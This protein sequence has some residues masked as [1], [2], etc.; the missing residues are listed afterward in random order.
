MAGF[1][2]LRLDESRNFQPLPGGIRST[3]EAAVITCQDYA[4]RSGI[5]SI[6]RNS[7]G[8]TVY[9]SKVPRPNRKENP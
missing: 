5:R 1:Y 8:K 6:V 2:V 9:D 4:D 3:E 7:D